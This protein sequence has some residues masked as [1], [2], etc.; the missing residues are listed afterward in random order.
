MSE[1]V[2]YAVDGDIA[3]LTIGNPPV[4][5]LSPGVPEGI[6]DGVERAAAAHEVSAVVLI[7]GG[8]TFIAGADIKEFGKI[9][10]GER[11][12]DV[13]LNPIL[14]AIEQSPKPVVAA[15]HGTALGGGLETA[16][17]CH[18]RVAAPGAQVGQP[19]VKLG[20]IPGA[21]G[22]QRLPRLAGVAAALEMCVSGEPVNAARALDYGIVDRIVEGDLLPAAVAFAREAAGKPFRRT[23]DRDEKLTADPALFE[24][25]RAQARKRR[26]LEIAPVAAIAAIEAATRLPFDEGLAEEA[27]LFLECLFS[28]QSKALIHVFFGERTVSKIPGIGKEVTPLPIRRAAVVGAGTMGTGIAMTYLNAGIPVSLKDTDQA[29]LERG[30]ATIRKNHETSATKGRLSPEEVQRRL[31]LLTPTLDY[32]GAAQA[33]IVVEA[34]FENMALKKQVFAEIDAAARDGAM[35]ATNTSTLD[36]DGIASATRRPEWVVGHHFFSPAHVMRLLE[37]VRGAAT[38][39]QVLAT[40]MELA[41]RLRKVGVVAANRRGFIGNRMFHP[42]RRAAQLLVEEG[43]TPEDVDTALYEFGMA[44]G[45]LAVGDLAGLDVGWRIRQETPA[46][47]EGAPVPRIEDWLCERGHFGQKTGAG[48]YLYDSERRPSHNPLIDEFAERARRERGIEPREIGE[49]EIVDR[50]LRALIEEGARVLDEKVAAGSVDIDIVYVY[51]YG[52]P[53]WRGGPMF[54]A[55]TAAL[56]ADKRFS[57]LPRG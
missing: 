47:D 53:A 19:E 55:D 3:V 45:P 37:I 36:I 4:N 15:I 13:G 22:T 1:L 12:R 8:R 31:S 49:E 56:F 54:Y 6:R 51:G 57:E 20:L 7:G 50:C 2:R 29:A 48:W 24:A 38:S 30:V 39:P 17:A 18:Y 52:F 27:R 11:P 10:S 33:D 41:R 5:A 46:W 23:R 16:M 28:T 43:A 14:N 35:L 21:G 26:R 40:S 25:A 32:D 34:V 44:M 9:T 42:Y